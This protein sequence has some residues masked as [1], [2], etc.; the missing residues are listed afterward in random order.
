MTTTFRSDITAG[1]V[2][3]LD[4]FIATNPTLLRR[5]ER[6]RPPS[7]AGDL[8]IAF[9]DGRN[10]DIRHDSGTRMRV[11][12]PSVLVVSPIGDNVET[13]VRHDALVD[14]LLDHFTSYPHIIPGTIWDQMAVRDEDYRVDS[15]DDTRFF[16]AT[17]FTFGNL[18]ILEGR[19]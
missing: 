3:I 2:T 16:F 14:L 1:L 7:I 4:A 12:T 13:V 19:S 5:S 10:E 9:V 18:S 6:A 15:N 17:R 8:P 11:M